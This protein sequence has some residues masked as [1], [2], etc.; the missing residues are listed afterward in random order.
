[1]CRI[2]NRTEKITVISKSTLE[3]KIN[4]TTDNI[5]RIEDEQKNISDMLSSTFFG[6]DL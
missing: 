1:M 6:G 2:I 3:K 4:E 5:K